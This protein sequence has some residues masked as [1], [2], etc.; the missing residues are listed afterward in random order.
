MR[1]IYNPRNWHEN[2]EELIAVNANSYILLYTVH[3]SR[4]LPWSQERVPLSTKH[5]LIQRYHVRPT[6]DQIQVLHRFRHPKWR[7][8]ILLWRW[9]QGNISQCRIAELCCC[10]ML[11]SLIYLPSIVSETLVAC[12]A[13]EYKDRLYGFGAV[14]V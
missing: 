1:A 14:P 7:H 6:E 9:Q 5:E 8:A 11:N 13:V 3:V 12:D 10:V 2:P 4:C